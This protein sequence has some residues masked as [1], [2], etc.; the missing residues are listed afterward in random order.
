[1]PSAFM[2]SIVP[3]PKVAF[4]S[5]VPCISSPASSR[6][7]V[8]PQTRAR[9]SSHGFSAATPPTG[10]PCDQSQTRD[11]SCPWTSLVVST[12]RSL[13]SLQL[14]PARDA[15]V[16]A[17]LARLVQAEVAGGMLQVLAQLQARDPYRTE[18]IL[19][20]VD[21]RHVT[22]MD[23]ALWQPRLRVEGSGRRQLRP[24]PAALHLIDEVEQWRVLHAG[25]AR[26]ES[27]CRGAERGARPLPRRFLRRVEPLSN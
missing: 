23:V 17:R 21:P 3:R 1:M 24:C 2:A 25:V 6:T 7:E 22:L 8:Q 10:R 20:G 27:R 19:V 18:R 5:S 15:V 14:T 13:L 11:S 12:R 26:I 4:D 16:D 9:L